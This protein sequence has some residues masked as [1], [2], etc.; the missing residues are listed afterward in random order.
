MYNM[1]ILLF[2]NSSLT[3]KDNDFCIETKTGNFA[4]E[5]QKL[6]Y[7][8]TF[9][10][11]ITPETK[12]SIHVF[13]IKE[14][15]MHVA[16]RKRLNN[17]ILNYI[18]LYLKVIPA[19]LSS[20]FVYVFYPNA[21]KYVLLLAIIFR[22]KYGLYIRGE[23]GIKSNY[24]QFIYRYAYTIN[25][26]SNGFTDYV[27]NVA[28]K[29]VAYTIKPMIQ[30]DSINIVFDRKYHNKKRYELLYLGRLSFDKGLEEL[31]RGISILVEKQHNIY[32]K[33]VGTGE[34]INKL[35]DLTIQLN[36]SEYISFKGGVYDSSKIKQYY[37]DADIFILP[38][39]HEGFPRTLYE[40]MIFGTPIIT[41]FVGGIPTLMQNNINALEIMPKS[42]ESIVKIISYAITD[43]TQTMRPIANNATH[44]ISELLM[45]DKLSHADNLHSKLSLL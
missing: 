34:F 39:Y 19:I 7:D 44:L 20:D 2:D 8:I 15:A 18:L 11:Q 25:T 22:K 42:V 21:F 17:K 28:N 37:K 30:Y 6:G 32:L 40:A 1:R 41:T 16:G 23:Q 43:Y 3:I 9:F 29:N 12:N 26:V 5:L 13:K 10:G 33:I 14:N 27:N 4:K 35:K 36:L 24:S 38:T 31:I 45:A